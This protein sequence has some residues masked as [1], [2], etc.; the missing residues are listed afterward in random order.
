MLYQDWYSA[1]TIIE[2]QSEFENEC[3]GI[4]KT[5]R[6]NLNKI[7]PLMVQSNKRLLKH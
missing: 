1:I 2:R 4:N 5:T 6:K 7:V 3:K